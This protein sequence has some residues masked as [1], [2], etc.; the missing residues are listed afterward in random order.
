MTLKHRIENLE[1]GHVDELLECGTVYTITNDEGTVRSEYA[2][3][4]PVM[5]RGE[6]VA[7]TEAV[8]ITAVDFA[9]LLKS[10]EGKSRSL[11]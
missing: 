2:F 10:F 9:K 4:E 7:A 11:V 8:M 1:G 6:H 5:G 3:C